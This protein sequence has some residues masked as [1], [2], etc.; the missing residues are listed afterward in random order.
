MHDFKVEFN[1][2]ILCRHCCKQA[3]PNVNFTLYLSIMLVAKWDKYLMLEFDC[4]LLNEY[5]ALNVNRAG[6]V[7]V[8]RRGYKNLL[9]N[10]Y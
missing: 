8:G 6:V 1:W 9:N 10:I 3:L 5:L 7:L 2:L 4:C